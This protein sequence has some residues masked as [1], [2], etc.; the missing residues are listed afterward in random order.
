MTETK[1][2]A[3]MLVKQFLPFMH[4][5]HDEVAKKQAKKCALITIDEVLQDDWFIEKEDSE[6]RKEFWNEVKIEVE[7]L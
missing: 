1:K 6:V 3:E 7:R 4:P 5:F 2:K